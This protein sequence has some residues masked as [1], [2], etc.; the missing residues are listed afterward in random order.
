M[1]SRSTKEPKSQAGSLLHFFFKRRPLEHETSLY[2]LVSVLDFYM[3]WWMLQRGEAAGFRFVESNPAAR[4]F[5]EQ[6]GSRGLFG[7]KIAAVVVVLLA[8]LLIAD[9][10]PAAARA[11]LWIGILVTGFVVAYSFALYARHTG[12]L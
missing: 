4:F 6:W 1:K 8:T 9:R 10:R 3:T 11:I 12:L 5:D 7:F 2:I